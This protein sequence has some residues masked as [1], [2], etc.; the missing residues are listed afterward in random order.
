MNK[1]EERGCAPQ[2]QSGTYR[3]LLKGARMPADACDAPA[4][5]ARVSTTVTL[6]P[7]L[8]SAR[9]READDAEPDD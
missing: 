1:V 5:G 4:P 6:T 2:G 7:R 3:Q 9:D 8:A